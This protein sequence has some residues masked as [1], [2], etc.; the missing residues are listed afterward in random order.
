MAFDDHTAWGPAK[1]TAAALAAR[2]TDLTDRGAVDA[3]IRA[4]NTERLAQR[5]TEE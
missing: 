2:G 5:L 4:L 3:G 1:E